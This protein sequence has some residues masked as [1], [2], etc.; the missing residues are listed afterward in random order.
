M[1]TCD[2]L[3]AAARDAARAGRFSAAIALLFQASLMQLDQ[4]GTVRYDPSR[5]AG[6]YRRLVMRKASAASSDFEGLA[7]AFTLA[8]FAQAPLGEP[9]WVQAEASYRS[10][11]PALSRR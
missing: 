3:Y 2:E 8:A 11:E 4:R 9:D 10:L 1:A 6:E 5:T 7:R